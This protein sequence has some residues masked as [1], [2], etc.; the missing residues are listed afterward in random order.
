MTTFLQGIAAALI[1]LILY[2]TIGAHSKDMTVL[3]SIGAC[4][5]VLY[6]GIQFLQ[7]VIELIQTLKETAKLDDDLIQILFK[8]VGIGLIGELA[9]LLCADGGNSAMGRAVEIMTAAAVLWLAI[10]LFQQL[11]TLIGQITGEL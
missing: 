4:I 9:A 11:L 6:C 8:V 3:L 2:L 7:P 5:L 1:G 10:P